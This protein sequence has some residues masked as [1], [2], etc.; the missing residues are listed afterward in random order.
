MANLNKE[1]II[2]VDVKNATVSTQ[3]NMTFYITDERTCNIYCQLVVNASKSA[4]I[5]K[6][7]SVDN[8]EDFTVTLR[9]IKPN[10][11]PK[12]LDFILL[13][14]ADA[15]F[16][17]DLEEEYKDCIGTYKCELFV[18]TTI[19]GELERVTTSSFTYKVNGSIMND[20]DEVIGGGPD[21]PLV[22]TL[23]T[24]VYVDD[25][26]TN[27]PNTN[28]L[29]DFAT[30][31]YVDNAISQ[32]EDKIIIQDFASKEYVNNR[33]NGV[34][35]DIEEAGYT[36]ESYV[37]EEITKLNTNIGNILINSYATK[38]E[39][40]TAINEALGGTDLSKYATQSYV[41]WWVS[42]TVNSERT[43]MSDHYATDEELNSVSNQAVSAT[44]LA[45]EALQTVW[46]IEE[47]YTTKDYV[48]TAI[49]NAQLGGEEGGVDLSHFATK[50][51]VHEYVSNNAGSGGS[52]DLSDYVTKDYLD[53]RNYATQDYVFT[54][55]NAE[56]GSVYSELNNNYATQDYVRE[57]VS[58][59]VSEY[60]GGS[61]PDL[62]D[63]A[64][65]E[66][67]SERFSTFRYED[68]PEIGYA[69]KEYVQEYVSENGGGGADLS[70][71]PTRDEMNQYVS[72]SISNISFDGVSYD[73]MTEYVGQR[74]E[75]YDENLN[76][77]LSNRG[78]ITSETMYD[79]VNGRFQ[80][81][82]EDIAE[83]GYLTNESASETYATNDYVNN[84]LGNIET[85]LGEI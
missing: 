82:N 7:H 76:E 84:M 80:S 18:D 49:A 38:S 29:N 30:V 81:H 85:L 22:K 3:G 28:L 50:D 35:Y 27:I 54:E 15:F 39:M 20:L 53:Q 65:K 4:L 66:Y 9:L 43:Y 10:N 12:E 68:L 34:K 16:Y 13:D 57:Y 2:T 67:V 31:N 46:Y 69:T 75:S 51:Y 58:E 47:N 14:K 6:Y 60:G 48:A 42:E 78:Y 25:S 55:L 40:N 36:T 23:A 61:T 62:S 45:G 70:E 63:Y 1:N 59:Y 73:T 24:R 21:Y 64:T 44:H 41:Q 83:R 8:A 19:N 17:I 37:N 79:Y 77:R 11:E 74:L 26:I 56:I 33:I 71:Y 5:T 32:H 72:D 52:V